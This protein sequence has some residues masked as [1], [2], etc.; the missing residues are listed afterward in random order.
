[1]MK[2]FFSLEAQAQLQRLCEYLETEWSESVRDQ[3]L[4]KLDARIKIL[5]QFPYSSPISRKK[6]AVHKCVVTPQNIIFYKIHKNEI[7]IIAIRDSRQKP[8]F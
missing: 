2:V 5:S 3:F 8:I 4:E 6:R 7:E 1:M